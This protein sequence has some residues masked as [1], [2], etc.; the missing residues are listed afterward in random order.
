[1][2]GCSFKGV[3]RKTSSVNVVFLCLLVRKVKVSKSS[4]NRNYEKNDMVKSVSIWPRIHSRLGLD[5]T[6]LSHTK[7]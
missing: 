5:L 4:L 7:L 3:S 6:L 1:M 2:M